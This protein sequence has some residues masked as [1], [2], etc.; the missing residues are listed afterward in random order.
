MQGKV[1]VVRQLHEDVDR[2]M[3]EVVKELAH[4]PKNHRHR[5]HHEHF[6]SERLDEMQAKRR[7]LASYYKEAEKETLAPQPIS[8][9]VDQFFDEFASLEQYHSKFPHLKVAQV[10]LL[11]CP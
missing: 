6:V 4:E 11:F 8:S 1:E 7:R 3:E 10:F 2:H 5:M 9:V